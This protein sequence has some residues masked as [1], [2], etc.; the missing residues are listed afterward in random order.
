MALL[1]GEPDQPTKPTARP[2][3]LVVTKVT[4]ERPPLELASE[5]EFDYRLVW[6]EGSDQGSEGYTVED[7][8]TWKSLR[9]QMLPREQGLE[10]MN[11]VGES[12]HMEHLQHPG[13]AAGKVLRLVPEPDNPYDSDAVKVCDA[14]GRFHAGYIAGE[15]AYRIGQK[16]KAG[17]IRACLSMWEV[18]KNGERVSLRILIID[19]HAKIELPK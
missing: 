9:W 2:A 7:A 14:S 4:L 16:I 6:N 17:E 11:I 13:F 12:H 1:A 15:Y 5:S 3:G 19:R 8:K 18:W 10:S